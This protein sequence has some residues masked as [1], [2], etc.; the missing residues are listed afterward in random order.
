M[1][2]LTEMRA[3]AFGMGFAFT[4]TGSRRA[5]MS[6]AV[7]WPVVRATLGVVIFDF[8]MNGTALA[9]TQDLA[10]LEAKAKVGFIYNLARFTEWPSNTFAHADEPVIIGVFGDERFEKLLAT[11]LH[12]KLVDGRS[13]RVRRIN[14]S[15]EIIGCH[16]F[17]IGA[18]APEKPKALF[19][20][21]EGRSILT[22]S[23]RRQF[24]EAGGMVEVVPGGEHKLRVN[25]QAMSR[26]NLQL[27]SRLL[28]LAEIVDG[29]RTEV[30]R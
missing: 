30:A 26:V 13:L 22:V 8:C 5:R 4:G 20:V 23:D 14:R 9:Q 24:P 6:W 10:G 29:R 15:D 3:R 16:I 18:G 25:L 7:V 28:A 17:Y 12:D 19:S 11:G 2:V 1:K 27:S 21:L